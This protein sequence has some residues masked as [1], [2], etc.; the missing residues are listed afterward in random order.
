[1]HVCLHVGQEGL[2]SMCWVL[3]FLFLKETFRAFYW[4]NSWKV[5]IPRLGKILCATPAHASGIEANRAHPSEYLDIF[6]EEN[7]ALT[8]VLVLRPFPSGTRRV[9]AGLLGRDTD[10]ACP[11]STFHR[12]NGPGC[13]QS[14]LATD[15]PQ[16]GR[17]QAS[18]Q[19]PI[20][21]QMEDA[22]HKLRLESL[23]VHSVCTPFSL[24]TPLTSVLICFMGLVID[25]LTQT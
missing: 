20:P 9:R 1:M 15:E 18:L 19:L 21:P 4:R 10:Q 13:Q 3:V 7:P 8:C 25:A 14:A 12:L 6:L 2:V 22:P 23:H 16:A 17:A 24:F 5:Q 11:M